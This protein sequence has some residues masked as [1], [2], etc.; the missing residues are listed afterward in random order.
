MQK[1]SKQGFNHV[2]YCINMLTN[3]GNVDLAG[4]T[5]PYRCLIF[6]TK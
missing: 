4:F 6:K 2:A 5:I 3:I 1:A